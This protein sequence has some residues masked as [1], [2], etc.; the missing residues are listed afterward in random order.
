MG[1]EQ[2]SM[3]WREGQAA[4]PRREAQSPTRVLLLRHGQTEG[5]RLRQLLGVTDLPLNDVGRTQAQLLGSWLAEHERIDGLYSSALA[6]AF[7]TAVIVGAALNRA[8]PHLVDADLNE[9]DFGE[10]EGAPVDE[11][12]I[13]YPHLADYVD[14]TLPEHPD[15]QWPGGDFRVA[16]YQRAVDAVDRLAAQHGGQTVALVTHGGVITGYLHW[17]TSRV[18]GFSVDFQVDNCSIT[19]VLWQPDKVAVVRTGETPWR[20]SPSETSC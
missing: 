19:E 6:R 12:A 18:L 9:M 5:N 14:R 3:R 13:R 4:P 7:E 2:G 15:W 10:A 20:H 8:E 1:A 11:L 16:Y 17:L